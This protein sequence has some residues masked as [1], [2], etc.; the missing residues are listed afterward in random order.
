MREGYLIVLQDWKNP[1]EIQKLY[2]FL[3]KFAEKKIIN[4]RCISS[5]MANCFI[6]WP[7]MALFLQNF[8]YIKVKKS[9]FS[10][11]RTDRILLNPIL[12][13][14]WYIL[15]CGMFTFWVDGPW[16]Y[17][18]PQPHRGMYALELRNGYTRVHWN[19][20]YLKPLKMYSP[21]EQPTDFVLIIRKIWKHNFY[22]S[23]DTFGAK[24]NHFLTNSGIW[25]VRLYETAGHT[26]G[27]FQ[28]I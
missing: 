16:G 19:E 25:N 15:K 11:G 23:F 12:V 17:P 7:K 10:V 5:I 24:I 3:G 20:I 26:F 14:P 28:L 9:K 6:L 1:A 13:T 21:K 4:V 18:P 8:K 27:I 2:D 22:A